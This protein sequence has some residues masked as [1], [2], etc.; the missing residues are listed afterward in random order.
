MEKLP[1][2]K[3]SNKCGFYSVYVCKLLE[4]ESDLTPEKIEKIVTNAF[5]KTADISDE[6]R[7]ISAFGIQK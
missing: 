2:N 4:R 5:G 3:P 6:R 1:E 7:I